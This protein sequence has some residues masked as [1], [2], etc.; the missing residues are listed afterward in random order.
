[1]S[2]TD[3]LIQDSERGEYG[4][5]KSGKFLIPFSR[6]NLM[7]T[8]SLHVVYLAALV[9][10]M[11]R[12]LLFPTMWLRVETISGSSSSL[13]IVV[14]SFSCGRILGAPLFGVVSEHYN[15]K[16]VLIWCNIIL[17]IGALVFSAASSVMMLVVAQLLMGLGA[18]NLATLRAYVAEITPRIKRSEFIA[19]LT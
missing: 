16:R 14:A 5:T 2:E 13:G 4:S 15:Y 9:S 6:E 19:Y 18:G 1:M 17:I 3:A 11:A 8:P 12:G 7:H 10:E